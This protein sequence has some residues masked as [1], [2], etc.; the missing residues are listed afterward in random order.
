MTTENRTSLDLDSLTC[1]EC[2]SPYFAHKEKGPNNED[3]YVCIRC[4]ARSSYE[5]R[6]QHYESGFEYIKGHQIHRLHRCLAEIL[7]DGS[8]V[9]QC[10]TSRHDIGLALADLQKIG[11]DNVFE[12]LMET[13]SQVVIESDENA[14]D[15]GD[16]ASDLE[17]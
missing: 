5:S 9:A 6:R 1:P 3:L 15:E 17:L 16:S 2:E 10:K 4:E 11:W 8:V 14:T 13:A 7:M 12:Y